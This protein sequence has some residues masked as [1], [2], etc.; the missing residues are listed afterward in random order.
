MGRTIHYPYDTRLCWFNWIRYNE[1][2]YTRP[3][4]PQSFK[5]ERVPD[6][7]TCTTNSSDYSFFHCFLRMGIVIVRHLKRLE[8][9]I[10][11][12]LEISDSPEEKTRLTILTVLE[13]TIQVAW[14]RYVNSNES[15]HNFSAFCNHTY[16]L[17]RI[18]FFTVWQDWMPNGC[19][20]TKSAET[21]VW[22]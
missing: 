1:S 15:W 3:R 20:R 16:C 14:P 9:V 17:K 18:V 11:G 5:P 6:A 21:A 10:I 8:R 4:K 2:L 22:C 19:F 13:K 7:S 12:Y